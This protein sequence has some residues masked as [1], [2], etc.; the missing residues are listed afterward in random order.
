MY[1]GRIQVRPRAGK[2]GL[3]TVYVHSQFCTGDFVIIMDAD[4]SPHPNFIAAMVEVHA[5][6]DYDIVT[7]TRYAGNGGVYAGISSA[8]SCPGAQT[9]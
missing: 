6:G 1:P 7:G 3:G 5:R 2:L 4:F 8:S 9:S